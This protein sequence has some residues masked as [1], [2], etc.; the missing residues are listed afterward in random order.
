M[1]YLGGQD[2][3]IP[4]AFEG[5]AHDALAFAA[6]V[7][8]GGV[9]EV[10]ARFMGKIQDGQAVRLT[11]LPAKGHG[12]HAELGNVQAGSRQMIVLHNVYPPRHVLELDKSIITA[13]GCFSQFRLRRALFS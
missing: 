3:V 13:F 12:A 4:A 6:C 8:V 10:D 5:L 11:G 7:E 2:D 1:A 9:P